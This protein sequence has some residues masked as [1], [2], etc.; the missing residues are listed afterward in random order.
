MLTLLFNLDLNQIMRLPLRPLALLVS[1]F[2]SL[3]ANG[4]V[5]RAPFCSQLFTNNILA[6]DLYQI[7]PQVTLAESLLKQQGLQSKILTPE[8]EEELNSLLGRR[9]GEVAR[10]PHELFQMLQ[11][12]GAKFVLSFQFGEISAKFAVEESEQDEYKI[13]ISIKRAN[14]KFPEVISLSESRFADGMSRGLKLL[15]NRV[16]FE[17]AQQNFPGELQQTL[18]RFPELSSTDVRRFYLARVYLESKN[19]QFG[20]F[21]GL[22]AI[23]EVQ[24]EDR[25]FARILKLMMQRNLYY[26]SSIYRSGP[27]FLTA[28]EIAQISL[29]RIKNEDLGPTAWKREFEL[30]GSKLQ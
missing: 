2:L 28:V 3:N 5:E 11:V 1:C 13:A 9:A 6:D 12:P 10:H 14:D 22:Q 20:L 25:E 19:Y 4:R 21:S 18:R 7:R 29:H 17:I 15:Q 16:L 8:L 23:R 30:T 26:A 27:R 24:P